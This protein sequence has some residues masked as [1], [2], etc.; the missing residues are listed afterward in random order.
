MIL[1]IPVEI[2]AYTAR[3]EETD[4][5]P[6]ITASGQTVR[7][8]IIALSRDLEKEFNL[9]FGDMV[10]LRGLGYFEFQDRMNKRMRHSVDIFMHNYDDAI[11]FG[12]KQGLLRLTQ[13]LDR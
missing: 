6:T 7:V 13:N 5:T 10:E 2:T 9:K 3:P 12:R 1:E 8:G 4:S 11:R